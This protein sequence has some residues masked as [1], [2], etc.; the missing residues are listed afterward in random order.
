VRARHHVHLGGLE[1]GA[2]ERRQRRRQ[3]DQEEEEAPGEHARG[4]PAVAEHVVLG[5]R[6]H[7]GECFFGVIWKMSVVFIYA[8]IDSIHI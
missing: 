7:D 5:S 1:R 4:E 8:F 3:D 2:A 6:R